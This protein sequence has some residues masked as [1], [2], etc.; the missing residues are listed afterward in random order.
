MKRALEVRVV[1]D[2]DVVRTAEVRHALLDR[3]VQVMGEP[4]RAVLHCSASSASE[5]GARPMDDEPKERPR[6]PATRPSNRQ[7]MDGRERSGCAAPL[8]PRKLARTQVQ[9]VRAKG[10]ERAEFASRDNR[11]ASVDD[12][13][14]GIEVSLSTRLMSAEAAGLWMV[15]HLGPLPVAVFACRGEIPRSLK[16]RISRRRAASSHAWEVREGTEQWRVRQGSLPGLAHA[17][18]TVVAAGLLV[19][20]KRAA[21]TRALVEA[22]GAHAAGSLVAIAGLSGGSR[23]GLLGHVI[24]SL[25]R[26]PA[27]AQML[28]RPGRGLAPSRPLRTRHCR[29]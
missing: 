4:L 21:G 12:D 9:P 26:D 2:A 24:T 7:Y 10:P 6:S 23:R 18:G 16:G 5:P 25:R 19:S 28:D 8:L 3:V 17:E 27:W 20:A 29:R 13:R 1:F 14:M 11:P 15:S 22:S